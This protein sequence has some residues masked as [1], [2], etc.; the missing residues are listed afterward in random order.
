[1]T[2]KLEQLS[3]YCTAFYI[4]EHLTLQFCTM[5]KR[6]DSFVDKFLEKWSSSHVDI[7]IHVRNFV[8]PIEITVNVYDQDVTNTLCK[9]GFQNKPQNS[10][11]DVLK[12][13]MEGLL[14][15]YCKRCCQDM[16]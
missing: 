2:I 8:N 14:V 10:S 16:E 7:R 3:T 13:S 4:L 5:D 15:A 11:T 1:M 6:V 9:A 12:R